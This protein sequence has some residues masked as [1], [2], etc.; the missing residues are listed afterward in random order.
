MRKR[1]IYYRTLRETL[2]SSRFLQNSSTFRKWHPM[3]FDRENYALLETAIKLHV[4]ANCMLFLL[5]VLT[6]RVYPN[7]TLHK[8]K[9]IEY[10]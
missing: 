3:D 6:I 2:Y 4:D 5:S 1:N 8:F 7:I 10:V 9:T